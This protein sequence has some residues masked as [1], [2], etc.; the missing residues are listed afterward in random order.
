MILYC[1]IY[2]YRER[3]NMIHALDFFQKQSATSSE[4]VKIWA[5]GELME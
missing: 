1:E 5:A 4:I 2:A 3:I